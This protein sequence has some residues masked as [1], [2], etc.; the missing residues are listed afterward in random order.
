[1]SL[2]YS[3]TDV[4]QGNKLLRSSLEILITAMWPF[5]RKFFLTF[6]CFYYY[7]V[8]AVYSLQS[9]IGLDRDFPGY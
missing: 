8:V 1:M 4:A 7:F 9:S 6:G 3:E 5:H 2:I